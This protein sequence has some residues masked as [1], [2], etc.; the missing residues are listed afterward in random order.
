MKRK[1][2]SFFL[3][4]LMGGAI[5]SLFEGTN[6]L[7]SGVSITCGEEM[8]EAI[9]Y[10]DKKYYPVYIY[11]LLSSFVSIVQQIYPTFLMIS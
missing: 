10:K 2:V 3:L 6:L 9:E 7:V 4:S 1:I 5:I 8:I 11:I